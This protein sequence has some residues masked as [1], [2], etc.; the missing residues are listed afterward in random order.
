MSG[1]TLSPWQRIVADNFGGGDFAY[2]SSVDEAEHVGDTLFLFLMR[3]LD[4]GEECDSWDEAL[5]RTEV[6]MRQLDEIVT[7]MNRRAP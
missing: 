5:R 7:L 2:I 4:P 3:E 1:D 6:A